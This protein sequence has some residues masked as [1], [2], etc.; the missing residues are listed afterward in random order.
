MS[1]RTVTINGKVYDRKTGKV[2]RHE[3]GI[4]TASKPVAGSVHTSLQKSRILN[5]KYVRHDTT[6]A[7]SKPT[8]ISVTTTNSIVTRKQPT[9]SVPTNAHP[10]VK[11]FVKP[12]AKPVKHVVIKDIAPTQHHLAQKV[13][14]R[15][16]KPVQHAP[17][18]S[19][20][21]KREAIDK[22]TASMPS[23]R[24]KP[25]KPAR[26]SFVSKTLGMASAA[27]ALL[28]M[29]GYLTY[30]TMP[31]LSTRVAA[32]Q[33]GI[34]ATY[35][36]YKPSGYSLS[37]PVAFQQGNV[38]MKFAANAGPQSYTV[39][40]SKSG[41]DSSAVLDNYVAPKVGNNYTTQSVNGLTIYTYEGN[42]AW[43]NS[44]ILYTISGNAPLSA[45]QVEHIATSM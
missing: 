16:V 19:Q 4:N 13:A 32:A 24:Q 3:R 17:K 26:K 38:T 15:S 44:G 23:H 43:I 45:E 31:S 36:A 12:T 21:L 22:A 11:R 8:A 41:W 28:L 20:I 18:P 42:A 9:H 34:D 40:Q 30:L 39:S 33:A 25:V 6:T 7:V 1:N 27:M 29:G 14:Q 35:P 2:L 5:R 10:E 37:G